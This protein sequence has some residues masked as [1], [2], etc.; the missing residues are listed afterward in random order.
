MQRNSGILSPKYPTSFK[1]GRFGKQLSDLH[2]QDIIE[3]NLLTMVEKVME[4]LKDRY[5]IRPISYEGL[6]RME[7]LEYPE[8]ALR[9]LI[10]NSI[11]HKDYSSTWTFLKVYDDR[12]EVWNPGELPEELT[13][14]KLRGNHSS[15]PRNPNIASVFFLAGYIESWGRGT[16]RIIET[17]TEG[18]LPEPIIEED[19]KGLRVV[20]LKDIY[21]EEYLKTIGLPERQAKAILYMKQYGKI[22]NSEYQSINETSHRTAARDL[23]ELM[24]K[25]LVERSGTT[26]KGT[27][28]ILKLRPKLK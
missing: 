3:T 8:P 16:N 11:I 1:I 24:E 20:F 17:L 7:P 14:E 6:E 4:K 18:G 19:M 28:Y 15:Y 27:Y 5:L 10:L 21:T 12:L 9:E 2:F 23:Q 22:T 26:G 13:V 25:Q